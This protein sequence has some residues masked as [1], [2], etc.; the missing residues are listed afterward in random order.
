MLQRKPLGDKRL[1]NVC[2]FCGDF[3][4]TRDHVPSKIL[5]DEP[6][7]ENLPVVPC[8]TK[9]NHDFSLDEEYITCFLECIKCGSVEIEDLKRE[10]IK[11]VLTRKESLRKKIEDSISIKDD[12]ISFNIDEKRL[13]NVLLK[14]ARGHIRFECDNLF[15]D[16]LPSFFNVDFIVNFSE[17]QLNN[18]LSPSKFVFLPE[19]G[20]RTFFDMCIDANNNLYTK[21]QIVQPNVYQYMISEN[22]SSVKMIIYNMLAVEIGW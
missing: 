21:W 7:P 1:E 20:S 16:E 22:S 8:C 12:N 15:I 4:D 9:C 17:E 11:N 18:F 13:Q 3:A 5:L 6:F 19:V 10:K 14:L 2:T